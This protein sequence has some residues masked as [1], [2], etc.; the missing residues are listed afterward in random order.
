MIIGV[1]VY[2]ILN[3]LFLVKK[4][5]QFASASMETYIELLI[6]KENSPVSATL[7]EMGHSMYPLA[8][9]MDIVPQKEDYR[10]GTTY[11]WATTSIIPNVF[12]DKHPAQKYANLGQWLMKKQQLDYGPGYSRQIGYD[13]SNSKK[14]DAYQFMKYNCFAPATHFNILPMFYGNSFESKKGIN[15]IKYFKERI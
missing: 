3:V 5:R 4:T 7:S 8:A 12:G 1:G 6:D 13:N 2:V 10:Y 14:V 9:T 15:H 11:L